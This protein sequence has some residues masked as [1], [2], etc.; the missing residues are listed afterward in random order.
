MRDRGMAAKRYVSGPRP[1]DGFAGMDDTNQA[2]NFPGGRWVGI[3]NSGSADPANNPTIYD[4][5]YTDDFS[6]AVWVK[7]TVAGGGNDFLFAKEHAGAGNEGYYLFR[8]TGS[9]GP[10]GVTWKQ[11]ASCCKMAAVYDGAGLGTV[12]DGNWHFLVA[13]NGGSGAVDHVNTMALYMDGSPVSLGT[14]NNNINGSMLNTSPLTIGSRQNGN[15]V[16]SNAQLDNAAIWNRE[17]S[18]SEV[19]SLWQAATTAIP[20]PCSMLLAVFGCG[21]VLNMRSRRTPRA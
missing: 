18:A 5:D 8:E 2:G 19:A 14:V 4:F 6:M 16:T 21:I 3:A 9:F 20:E 1:A 11:Q 7:K 12:D 13:T 17:L 10:A 15:V